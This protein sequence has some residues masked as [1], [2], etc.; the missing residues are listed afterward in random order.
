MN[1]PSPKWEGVPEQVRRCSVKVEEDEVEERWGELELLKPVGELEVVDGVVSF[2]D[3]KEDCNERGLGSLVLLLK[4]SKKEGGVVDG[5]V[6]EK[7]KLKVGRG[8]VRV[9]VKELQG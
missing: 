3:V 8:A 2:V 1:H 9:G 4:E 6:P 5:P 7:A